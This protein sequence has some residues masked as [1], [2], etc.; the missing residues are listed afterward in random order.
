MGLLTQSDWDD[1]YKRECWD[2]VFFDRFR[3]MRLPSCEASI[4]FPDHYFDIVFIDGSHFK[5]DVKSDIKAWIG[6]VRKGGLLT[7]HDYNSSRHREVKPA[8]DEVLGQENIEVS[9]L[10]CV[11]IHKIV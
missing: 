5:D 7:G 10:G 6:K 1:K 4:L 8:V 11:W 3:I 2:M 9:K